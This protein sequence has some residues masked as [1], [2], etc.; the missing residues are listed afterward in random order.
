MTPDHAHPYFLPEPIARPAAERYLARHG[1]PPPD[2]E[3]R[4]MILRRVKAGRTGLSGFEVE[5]AC[6]GRIIEPVACDRM[7]DD[8]GLRH[9][10]HAARP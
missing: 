1:W 8:R 2:W 6:D 10:H 4:D 7:H 3:R 5:E 9:H